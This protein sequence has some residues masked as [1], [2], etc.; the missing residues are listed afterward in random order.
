MD[1]V[2]LGRQF[3]ERIH[4]PT[5]D[6][7]EFLCRAILRHD[8]TDVKKGLDK[9]NLDLNKLHS[10]GQTPLMLAI[11]EGQKEMVCEILKHKPDVTIED[12]LGLSA[13]MM[14]QFPALVGS[15]SRGTGS[16]DKEAIKDIVVDYF[17]REVQEAKAMMRAEKASLRNKESLKKKSLN[18]GIYLKRRRPKI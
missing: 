14:A 17:N 2:E 1:I 7:H 11:F 16:E 15:Q 9:K 8:F 10:S 3:Q 4:A 6:P 18:S 13:L 5:N 12:D